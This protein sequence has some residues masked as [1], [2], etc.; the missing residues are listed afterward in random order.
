VTRVL[1]DIDVVLD[2]LAN[3][4]P[5]ADEAESVL[6]LVEVR[7]IEGLV[8]AHTITALQFPVSLLLQGPQDLLRRH[9]QV[10][11]PHT[12]GILDGVGYGGRRGHQPGLPDALGSEWAVG[13]VGLD[14]GERA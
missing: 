13:I 2:V 10:A 3:H 7:A 4:E 11:H 8:A 12:E 1:L 14:E 5:F 9:G 6:R